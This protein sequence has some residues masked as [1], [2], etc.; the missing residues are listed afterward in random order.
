M[1]SSCLHALRTYDARESS[2]MFG[3]MMV[4]FSAMEGFYKPMMLSKVACPSGQNCRP[5]NDDSF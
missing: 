2:Y 4:V 1:L 3:A 5:M